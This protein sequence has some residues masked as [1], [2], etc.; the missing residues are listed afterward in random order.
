MTAKELNFPIVYN[1][2]R[3]IGY[4]GNQEWFLQSWKRNSGCGSTSGANLAA[5]YAYNY[6]QMVN[7]YQG[8]LINFNQNEYLRVMEEM[9]TYMKPGPMGFPYIKKFGKKFVQ[10]CKN[11][12]ISMEA[13]VFDNYKNS[14]AAFNFVRESID[15][16]QPIALLILLHRAKELREYTWHWVT[17]TGYMEDNDNAR[18]SKIIIS[19]YGKREVINKDMMFEVHPKNKIRMVNFRIK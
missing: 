4:G 6:P 15:A 18:A 5:Y 3:V 16:R 8:D 19:N 11:H 13:C 12:G 2:D 9:F 14:D 7:I 1:K 17:I 10:F